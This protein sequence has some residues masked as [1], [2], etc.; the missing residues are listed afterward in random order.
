MCYEPQSVDSYD[1]ALWWL[2]KNL[3]ED[4]LHDVINGDVMEQPLVVRFVA[5]MF[6]KNIRIVRRDLGK[7]LH[8]CG[9]SAVR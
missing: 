9:L 6:W 5:D 1:Q 2:V 4:Q 8:S 7:C 3:P